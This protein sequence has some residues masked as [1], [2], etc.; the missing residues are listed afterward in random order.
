MVKKG[1]KLSK[2]TK[3]KMSEALKGHTVSEETK[4]KISKTMNARRN[5]KNL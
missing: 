3:R 1:R 5:Q 2:A 4:R